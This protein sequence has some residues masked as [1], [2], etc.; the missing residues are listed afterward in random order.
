M[1]G[2]RLGYVLFQFRGILTSAEKT[3]PSMLTLNSPP[4]ASV[5]LRAIESPRPL[6]SEVLA[7]SPRT[8]LSVISSAENFIS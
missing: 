4:Q 3:S 1:S 7:S 6:P 5:K 8:N 2:I